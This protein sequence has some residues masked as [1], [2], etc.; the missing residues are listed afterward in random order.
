[1]RI[2]LFTLILF[3]SFVGHTQSTFIID[4]LQS[5]H[6]SEYRSF[7]VYKPANFDNNKDYPVLYCTDG[8]KMVEHDY[9]MIFDSLISSGIIEP[10]VVIGAYSNEKECGINL[11]LRQVEY[12]DTQCEGKADEKRY[13]SH[14]SFFLQEL[15]KHIL[16]KYGVKED[17]S[18][19]MFFGVSNGA[20]FGM[21]LF[22]TGEKKFKNYI[23]LSTLRNVPVKKNVYKNK[24]QP[25]LYVSYGSQEFFMLVDEYENL[26]HKLT[27]KKFKFTPHKYDG[28]H[29][30]K[31]WKPELVKALKAITKLA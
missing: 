3:K 31:D 27:R 12:T 11:T 15:P 28:G 19:T 21:T 7:F 23:C 20:G 4:S 6:L 1:M 24:K 26:V 2:A 17:S 8:Q 5:T 16:N 30:D 10:I 14:K 18:K 22:L 29:L 9:K 25:F 13:E